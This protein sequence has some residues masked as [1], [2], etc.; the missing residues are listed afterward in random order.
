ML[1]D[2]VYNT[3]YPNITH[4]I[5]LIW[6]PWGHMTLKI[7][8]TW[9]YEGSPEWTSEFIV[10]GIWYNVKDVGGI[11]RFN[12]EKNIIEMEKVIRIWKIEK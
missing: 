11:N 1:Q 4:N 10:L 3:Y 8:A 12:I 9:Y 7:S 2:S 6:T 5:D